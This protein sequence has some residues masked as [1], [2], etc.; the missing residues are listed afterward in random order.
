MIR[1]ISE[2]VV[3]KLLFYL[4]A[5]LINFWNML[6][7]FWNNDGFII[8]GYM[9]YLTLLSLFPF[10]IFL[11]SLAGTLGR[12]ATGLALVNTTLNM[13]PSDIAQTLE[14][15]INEVLSTAQNDVLTMSILV[16]FW[17]TGSYIE[18]LRVAIY[19]AYNR[20]VGVQFW[21]YRLQSVFIVTTSTLL[22]LLAVNSQFALIG[23]RDLIIE[24]FPHNDIIRS[25][26][27]ALRFFIAPL[28][29]YIGLLGLYYTLSPRF[30]QTE[31]HPI[32]PGAMLTV[33]AW[34]TTVHYLPVAISRMGR[35][36]LTYGS[37]A[38]IMI[39]LLFFY[40]L[41]MGA[42]LGAELNGSVSRFLKEQK[43]QGTEYIS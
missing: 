21:I 11:V 26:I 32:W 18:A 34:A 37:L 35:Y 40:I 12:T 30:E 22:L 27:S 1:T 36:D 4:R 10:V 28:M 6:K 20:V 19:K 33:F 9:A 42:V 23:L 3:A 31:K 8:S 13:L 43:S 5:I 15:P 39:A 29:V 38:S 2:K 24:F 41:G 16:A 14:T 7:G 25:H 17:T